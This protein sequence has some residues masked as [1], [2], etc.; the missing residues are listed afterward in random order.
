[1]ESEGDFKATLDPRVGSTEIIFQL[2]NCTEQHG[3]T[4]SRM[5][6]L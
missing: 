3:W 5:S 2:T 4:P 6:G 1:M